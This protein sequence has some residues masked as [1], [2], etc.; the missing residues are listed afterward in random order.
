MNKR[1]LICAGLLALC[2]GI[3]IF[4]F[5]LQIESR[6]RLQ[7]T[8]EELRRAVRELH[9]GEPSTPPAQPAVFPLSRNVRVAIGSLGL[10]DDQANGEL[11]DLVTASLSRAEGVE[12]VERQALERVLQEINL[13]LSGLVRAKDAV[14]AGKLLPS[15]WFLLGTPASYRGTNW[16]VLRIVDGRTGIMR[17]GAIVQRD[18]PRSG[19]SAE[20]AG[21][22]SRS[23]KDAAQAQPRV[24]LAIGAFEDLSLNN[25]GAELPTELRGFPT[26]YQRSGITMLEREFV[27]TR[28]QEPESTGMTTGQVHQAD[29]EPRTAAGRKK[30]P[31]PPRVESWRV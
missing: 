10:A 4:L 3:G 30:F 18:Q 1:F 22:V 12:L 19:L 14:R 8:P 23:R 21:F 24:Y 25:R 7:V 6:D 13:N 16:L 27:R 11:A 29:N 17:D 15:D 31:R 9:K 2:G 5:H 28:L 26:S 20:I